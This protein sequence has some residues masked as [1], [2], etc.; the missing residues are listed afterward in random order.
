MVFV[1][2]AEVLRYAG[3]GASSV[4]SAEAYVNQYV[5]TAESDINLLTQINFSDIY[6]TLDADTRD[7]LKECAGRMAANDVAG[8]DVQGYASPREQ[9]NIMNH[10]WKR[11]L[12][13]LKL[14]SNH[15]KA[16]WLKKQT[17]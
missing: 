16:E 17:S 5:A 10:N 4:S 8:Y 14:L 3:K 12:F 11:Y 15:G 6:S 9:E 2:T 13:L 1:T 7:S